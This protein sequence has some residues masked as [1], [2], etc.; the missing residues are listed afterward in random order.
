M[1]YVDTGMAAAA[2][3]VP[4][5]RPPTAADE[6]KVERQQ[7][8]LKKRIGDQVKMLREQAGLSQRQL[9]MRANI[10]PNYLS[11][12]ERGG[13]AV[14]TDFLVRVAFHLGTTP[15]ALLSE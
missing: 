5:E 4:L 10:S 7:N 8:L 6:A 3:R 2:R 9:G 15:V 13:R 12:V 11:N 1:M 14:T